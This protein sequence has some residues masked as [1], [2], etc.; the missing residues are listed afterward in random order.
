MSKIDYA[1][2]NVV[3]TVWPW[4]AI[5]AT[6]ALAAFLLDQQGR[7][8]ICQCGRV[9]LWAGDIWSEDNSQH[10]LDPYSFTHILHGF[11]FFWGIAWL[12]PRLAFGWQLWL[13]LF[14]E[15]AWEVAENSEAIIQRYRDATLA[16]G[17]NGDTIVNSLSDIL[18]CGLGVWL[19]RRI[20]FSRTVLLFLCTEIVLAF[21][22]RDGLLLNILM[23]IYPIDAIRTWQTAGQ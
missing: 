8:W 14:I 19:A 5:L 23:L 6:L 17:Y 22:I 3:N 18:L 21:W 2:R 10:I 12:W 7:L 20:G 16:L 11:I 1:S 9:D 4:V 13:A 15:A